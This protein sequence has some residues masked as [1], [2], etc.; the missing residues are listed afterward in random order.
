[1]P[2]IEFSQ[3]LEDADWPKTQTADSDAG[4]LLSKVGRWLK[5]R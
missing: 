2:L 4:G 1:L 5:K 3:L